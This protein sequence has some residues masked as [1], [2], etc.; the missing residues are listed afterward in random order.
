MAIFSLEA[1]AWKSTMRI[2]TSSGISLR[3]RS[4]AVQG[5][6]AGFMYICPSRT[7]TAAE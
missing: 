7:A 1:S 2:L 4:T 5:E 3:I 6:S